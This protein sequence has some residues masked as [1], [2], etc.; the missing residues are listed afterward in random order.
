RRRGRRRR[1]RARWG[2]LVGLRALTRR[3]EADPQ[4]CQRGE[5]A[6]D[7]GAHG[8]S[9]SRSGWTDRVPERTA[10]ARPVRNHPPGT[11]ARAQNANGPG[12]TYLPGPWGGS[13]PPK[14]QLVQPTAFFRAEPAEILT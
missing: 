14:F 6:S 7:H 4:N 12:R 8:V 13:W 2:R 1:R 9:V 3:A 10:V 5:A 11:S